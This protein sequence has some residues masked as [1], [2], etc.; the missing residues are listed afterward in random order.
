MYVT[1]ALN[2]KGIAVQDFEPFIVE[3][4]P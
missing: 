4:A 2:I 3:S 1:V